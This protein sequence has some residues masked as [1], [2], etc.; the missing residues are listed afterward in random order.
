MVGL[1]KRYLRK[2]EQY[3]FEKSACFDT[4]FWEFGLI[5]KFLYDPLAT[6]FAVL[7]SRKVLASI[8]RLARVRTRNYS[9]PFAV[10][11]SPYSLHLDCSKVVS[12]SS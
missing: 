5:L 2:A 11:M 8:K 6:T 3:F 4:C 9:V 1:L 12:I 7:A 10:S